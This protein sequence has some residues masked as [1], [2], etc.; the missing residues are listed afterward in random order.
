M[1]LHKP[2]EELY[3]TDLPMPSAKNLIIG[4]PYVELLGKVN[5][6]NH[7]T[8]DY[9]H[10]EYHP[11]RWG[12]SQAHVVDGFV[13]NA[14][15]K[16]RFKIDGRWNEW[17]SITDLETGLEEEIWR[18]KPRPENSDYLYFFTEFALQLNYLPDVL[19]DKLPHTDSRFR[20]DQRALENGDAKLAA[21]EKHRLEEAQRARRKEMEAKGEHHKPVYYEKTTI[22][23]TG[24]EIYVFNGQY[25]EDRKKKDW[26]K[27]K[28]IFD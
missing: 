28:R 10:L 1:R 5:M 13:Y 22:P 27:L 12:G 4:K 2:I 23:E 25:W 11:R 9:A 7:T 24:E 8:G 15:G 14:S 16:K 19:K 3:S 6:K 21:A 18:T 26:S 20:P 17:A